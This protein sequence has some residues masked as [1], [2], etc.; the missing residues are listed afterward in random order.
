MRNSVNVNHG[1][2]LENRVLTPSVTFLNEN[3]L[4]NSFD[5]QDTA[6]RTVSSLIKEEKPVMVDSSNQTDL[7]PPKAQ[8][9][10]KNDLD[11][12]SRSF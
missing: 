9:P 2:S 12:I 8:R 6:P 1:P 11:I 5:E 4:N 3:L 7:K 10:L